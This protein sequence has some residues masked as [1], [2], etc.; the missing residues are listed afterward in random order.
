M[1]LYPA[2]QPGGAGLDHTD[3]SLHLRRTGGI[4][5]ELGVDHIIHLPFD[6]KIA[7]QSAATFMNRVVYQLG[8]QTPAGGSEFRT[9]T[10]PQG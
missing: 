6:Q 4:A 5:G 10:R 2:S 7:S 1:T 9:G 8:V 3:L